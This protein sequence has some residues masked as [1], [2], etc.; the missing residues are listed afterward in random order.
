[1]GSF[2]LDRLVRPNIRKLKAYSS[3][4]GEFQ[5]S[6]D[7]MVLL[8]A[9]ES[10]YNNGL[11][12]YPD[13]EHKLLKAKLSEIKNI[14]EA[15]ILL[16]NGSDELISLLFNAFC[17]PREDNVIV[18]TPT[19]GMYEVQANITDIAIQKIT[20][21]KDFQPNVNAIL[22]ASDAHTKMLFIC[23]PNNPTG[24][25]IDATIIE[26]LLTKF[27]GLVVVDEAY[28]DFSTE[29]SWSQRLK[30]F[31]NLIVLQT[32]SKA[33]GLAGI[34][35]GMCFS[36]KEIIAV[37]HR[38]KLPYNLN[39]LTQ[40]KAL[41]KISNSALIQEKI[42]RI[43]EGRDFVISQLGTIDC[44]T[45]IYPTDANFVLVQFDDATKRYKQLIAKG[46]VVRNRSTQPLCDST[47]RLTIGTREENLNLLKALKELV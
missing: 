43:I 11:N 39:V 16:G 13:P 18:L 24:N 25:L 44:I 21:T 37:L 10:P 9:N 14:S 5:G 3:A 22:E 33:Y 45:K 46:I 8:D 2:N 23:S 17:Q 27:N 29:Q 38:L 12:R 41:E 35:L 26:E 19:F 40:K 31:P 4:R 1:M 20:L 6:E 30:E 7:S 32:L 34:R 28:I 42:D 47:L 15:H 36:S